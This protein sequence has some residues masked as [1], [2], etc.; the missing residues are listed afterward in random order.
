MSVQVD[1]GGGGG[2][3]TWAALE[4]LSRAVFGAMAVKLQAHHLPA[5]GHC[6]AED[7]KV[8]S[9]LWKDRRSTLDRLDAQRVPSNELR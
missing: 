4:G 5:E 7:G 2:A 3:E 8:F 6:S 9:N 1:A